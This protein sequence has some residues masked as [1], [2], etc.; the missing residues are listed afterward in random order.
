ML[1]QRLEYV[2]CQIRQANG[3]AA[4]LIVETTG[5]TAISCESILACDETDMLVL[6]CFHF[7][8]DYCEVFFKP[9]ILSGTKNGP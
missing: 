7:K 3:D 9:E 2:G 1:G 5:H 6:L 4:V 8:E